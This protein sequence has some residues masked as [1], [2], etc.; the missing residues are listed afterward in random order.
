[1]DSKQHI[2]N[3]LVQ[4]RNIFEKAE[5]RIEALKPGEKIPATSLAEELATELGMKGNQL[6]PTLLFLFKGYPGIEIRRGAHG[7]LCKLPLA[8]S[9][10]AVQPSE[11]EVKNKDGE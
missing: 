11:D 1:M 6:Y 8:T 3:V 2:D 4:V 9:P 10:A 7:G 5:A